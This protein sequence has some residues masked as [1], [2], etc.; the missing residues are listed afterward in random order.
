MTFR[1][2]IQASNKKLPQSPTP[3]LDVKVLIKKAFSLT[4]TGLFLKLDEE[5]NSM[6]PLKEFYTY[7][8]SRQ[9]EM[10]IAYITGEKEFYGRLFTI[11]PDVLI[12]RPETEF[13]I[14]Y[15]KNSCYQ[16]AKIL[17]LGTGSG[18]ISISLQFEYPSSL[19]TATDISPDALQIA[20][21]NATILT[22]EKSLR[23]LQSN[24]LSNIEDTEWD[25]IVAN[26]PYLDIKTHTDDSI[27]H[28][29]DI[30]LYAKA[31]GK[32]IYQKLFREMYSR[33]FYFKIAL[34]EMLDYQ[35]KELNEQVKNT[36]P[37]WTSE[38]LPHPGGIV[39]FLK[40]TPRH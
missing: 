21:K 6:P 1:E 39:S 30:A 31:E 20:T 2:L 13:I 15:L 10:P 35:A 11:T 4:E 36:Y 38:I 9:E 29:P 7:L 23:L 3:D 19:I 14:D 34:F 32:A 18:C 37:T 12:P 22:S 33:H 40:I 8:Q 17:E 5:I 16:P 24:L 27:R 28:E 26:L 25:I